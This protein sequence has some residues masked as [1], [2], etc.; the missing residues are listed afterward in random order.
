MPH[1][2][3][4]D[5]LGGF[6]TA[7]PANP[8]YCHQEFLEK[9][10]EHA[11]DG[12]GKRTTLLLQRLAVDPSRLHY[13]ATHGVNRGWRRSRL[14]GGGGSH[15]YAW[16][17]PKGAA[18][19]KEAPAFQDA[20]DGALFLRDIRHHDDHAPL[21]PQSFT[22]HYLPMT[23]R[24]LRRE[25]YSPAP[26]TSGQS[27]FASARQP[28]RIL[29]GHPGSGKTTALWHAADQTGAEK[30]LY[31]TYSRD[32]A[33]LAR[34][35]FDRYCSSE[36]SFRVVTFSGL[37]R[38]MLP[39]DGTP[40]ADR[41]VR[42]QFQR[43]LGVFHRG[44]GP[45][46][47]SPAALYDEMHAHLVGDAL[48]VAVG[49]FASS[50]VPRVPEWEYRAR[51][52]DTLGSAAVGSVLDVAVR[53]EREGPLAQRFFPELAL[54]WDAVARLRGGSV[55]AGLLDYDCI[56]V[57]EC[58][59]LT[60]IEAYMLVEIAAHVR[61]RRRGPVPVLF[62]GDEAQTVRPTDFEW[63]WLND[64]LHSRLGAPAEFKL[65]VNLR[66]PRRIAEI[67]NRV[68]DLYSHIEKRDR[69]SGAGVAEIDDDATDQIYYCVA[70]AGAELDQ[71]LENLSTREGLAIITLDNSVPDFVPE[72]LRPSVLSVSE[73]KGL[74]FHSVCVLDA[75][76][77]LDRIIRD[78]KPSRTGWDIEDLRKRLAID[79]LRVALSRPTERLLWIDVSPDSEIVR[80]S[81]RFLGGSGGGPVSPS[82]PAAV[83]TALEEDQL[84]LEERVQ[85]CQTDARQYLEVRPEIAWSR[86]QQAVT[87]LGRPDSPAC[88]TDEALRRA[89]H[90]TLAEICICLAMRGAKLPA[91]LGRPDLFDHAWWAASSAGRRGM[92]AV[93][94]EIETVERAAPAS[95]LN[96]V[97]HLS[98]TLP[99][100]RAEL[101]AWLL[102]EVQS[103]SRQWIGEL[104]AA[105]FSAENAGVLLRILPPFYEALSVPDAAAR[106]ALL[107]QRAVEMFMKEGRHAEAL[108]VIRGSPEKNLRLEAVCLEGMGDYVA[109]AASYREVG[110]RKEALRC[111]RLAPDFDAALALVREIGDHPAAESLEW[112][113]RLR[114]VIAERPE[115]FTRTM[116]PS[117]KKLLQD[118][119]EKSLG[120]ARRT[121][122]A[123]KPAT[124]RAAVKNTPTP[125]KRALP[126]PG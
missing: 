120:V 35:H 76:R 32:L 114:A 9:L 27:R 72:R 89:A 87:L 3:Q 68:W 51:R 56:A 107:R 67:V 26:W 109:A 104:E 15:F 30:V 21:N 103:R 31:V 112:V 75:G 12:V 45:W 37:V 125:R 33:A 61:S 60:P 44:L 91:E 41:E 110:D 71:L 116:L 14:G 83:L 17:T 54:A 16:W 13:K 28:V 79:Q 24:D 40:A 10:A 22:D 63:G 84:D 58:Q 18:P 77:Q 113:A 118:L 57:D 7:R 88:V 62:A 48:P 55:P 80:Q 39:V 20:P 78:Q 126:K 121:P 96:A 38:E 93:I 115:K 106:V 119:L 74:D 19:L 49:R 43:A 11:R 52:K 90:L 95:R 111:Y 6:Q 122:A 34:D 99:A 82:I 53:L 101:E 2:L 69:P 97:V 59:D 1:P 98:Q 29:K 47:D 70:V 4:Y 105:M 46:T 36:R 123:R 65:S 81:V 25:E 102:I 5:L 92:A 94:K 66:S 23:V 50:A 108:A 8:V 42:R 117:E 73:A 64:L 124:K 85:R 86:A 100:H